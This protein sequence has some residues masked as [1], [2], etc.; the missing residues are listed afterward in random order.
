MVAG[1]QQSRLENERL[2]KE[3][4]NAR[5]MLLQEQVSP[6]FLFN[7][8]GTLR[9]MV[10][11]RTA[12]EFI[13]NLAEVYR[14]L[15]NNRH[16]DWVVLKTE[17]EFAKAYLHILQQRFENAL[18]VDIDIT[19]AYLSMKLPPMTL[20]M[21]I[22]NSVKHNVLDT[23]EPLCLKIEAVDAGKLIIRNSLRLKQNPENNTGTG[24]N[25][26]RERYRL[27]V[28][29]DIEVLQ[30]SSEFIVSV[31]LLKNTL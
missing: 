29:Q 8:L 14:Y 4:L 2:K 5:L 20:Q 17:L 9:S 27:L 26:I 30:T 11:E 25:N 21:L 18:V 22:E 7:S 28:N 6:H 1:N 24:L 16:A 31:Y 10:S 23:D 15:L 19:E 12:R 13:Q 3:N